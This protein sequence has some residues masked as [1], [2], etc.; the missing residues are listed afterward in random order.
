M[1]KYMYIDVCEREINEPTFFDKKEKAIYH[2]VNDFC[3]VRDIGI[4]IV[5]LVIDEKTLEEALSILEENEFMNDENMVDI[6]SLLAYGT[7]LNHDNWDAKIIEVK[8]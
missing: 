6:E 3:T 2:M 7:T 4:D 1:K 8:I 5:P